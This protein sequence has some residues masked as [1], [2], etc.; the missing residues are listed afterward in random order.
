MNTLTLRRPLRQSWRLGV[1]SGSHG[2]AF[3]VS[4]KRWNNIPHKSCT[5]DFLNL[6]IFM[7]GACGIHKTR[8]KI[9][10]CDFTYYGVY[11]FRIFGVFLDLLL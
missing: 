3:A 5:A 4:Q 1:F 7:Q 6:F 8:L 2:L 10:E 9:L 11:S